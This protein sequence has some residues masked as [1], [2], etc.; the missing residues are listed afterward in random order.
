MITWP[1][2]D[3]DDAGARMLTS[4]E[5]ETFA[6]EGY[7]VKRGVVPLDK[8]EAA[9]DVVWEHLPHLRRDDPGKLGRHGP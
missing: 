2:S 1:P 3:D 6:T 4:D 5:I 7:V 9:V 8:V